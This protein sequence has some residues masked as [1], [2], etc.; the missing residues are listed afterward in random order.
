MK[1]EISQLNDGPAPTLGFV[2]SPIANTIKLPIYITDVFSGTP[3][4]GA[5][6]EPGDVIT[7]INGTPP[8]VNGQPTLGLVNLQIPTS[9]SKLTLTVTRPSTGISETVTLTTR[10][11]QTPVTTEKLLAS[12]IGYVKLFSFTS[13]AASRVFKS[14]Q[15]LQRSAKLTGLVLDLRNNLGGDVDQAVRII[16]AFVHKGIVSYS[17]DGS[18]HRTALTT[19]DSVPLLRIPV[20]VLI[21]SGSASSSEVV[22]ATVKDLRLGRVVGQTSAGALAGAEFFGLNDGSGMEITEEHVL[23]PKAEKIDG[24][25]V[26]PNDVVLETALDLSNG[27]DPVVTQAVKELQAASVAR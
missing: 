26:Q 12:N 7:A 4:S 2:I 21:D 23:G 24:V 11:L 19:V 27:R 9:G 16:S 18:G 6:L 13:D 17:V 5:G 3:A 15:A 10:T 25:G 1:A 14:I 22:A 8:V 20:V